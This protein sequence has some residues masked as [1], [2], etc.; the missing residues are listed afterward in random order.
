MVDLAIRTRPIEEPVPNHQLHGLAFAAIGGVASRLLACFES[1]ARGRGAR[2]SLVAV[3][4]PQ[5]LLRAFADEALDFA[6]HHAGDGFSVL[7]RADLARLD[8]AML[9]PCDLEL[10]SERLFGKRP[11]EIALGQGC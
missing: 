8:V 11:V 3:V 1:E 6:V 9:S 10:V 5:V 4:A 7:E 2:R